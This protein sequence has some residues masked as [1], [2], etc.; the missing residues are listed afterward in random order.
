[1]DAS[2]A[3]QRA[4]GDR[5]ARFE[6]LRREGGFTSDAYVVWSPP[7]P[8][9]EDRVVM[10]YDLLAERAPF[11]GPTELEWVI[12][13]EGREPIS[14]RGASLGTDGIVLFEEAA[15]NLEPGRFVFRLGDRTDDNCGNPAALPIVDATPVWRSAESEHFVYRW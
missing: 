5:R 14:R 1:M 10:L 12:R 6:R 3:T 7:W 8:R 4:T 9:R 11:H 13:P 15:T 2:S